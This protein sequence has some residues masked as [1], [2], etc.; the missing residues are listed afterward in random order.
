MIKKLG[1]GKVIAIGATIFLTSVFVALHGLT[2]SHF[3]VSLILLG[4]GWNFT[5]TGATVLIA[6]IHSP[7]ERAKVQGTNDFIIFTGLAFSSLMAGGIYSHFGWNWIN[8]AMLPVI[9]VILFSA[10]W[11][12]FV[13]RKGPNLAIAAAD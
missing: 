2:F 13:S 9:L 6:E 5:F 10:L 1:V 7:A 4:V 12:H 8:Y 3:L 11:L